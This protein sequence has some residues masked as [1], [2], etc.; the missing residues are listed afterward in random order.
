[1]DRV[2]MRKTRCR[3]ENDASSQALR[4]AAFFAFVV[5]VAFLASC[6]KVNLGSN[7]LNE[8]SGC[9]KSDTTR[10][11]F[12]SATP[13]QGQT[14]STLDFVDI[15]FTE[16]LKNPQPADVTLTSPADALSVSKIEKTSQYTYRLWINGA[17][18]NGEIIFSF[19]RLTD[20]NGNTVTGT[21]TLTG[22]VDIG[23]TFDQNLATNPG[24]RRG[25]SNQAGAYA[26]TTI[27]FKHDFDGDSVANGGTDANDWKV[28]RTTGVTAC[29]GAGVT[30]LASFGATTLAANSYVSFTLNEATD[31]PLTEQFYRIVVCVRNVAKNKFGAQGLLILRDNSA[32]TLTISPNTQIEEFRD[33]QSIA[34]TCSND[35][36]KIA[37]RVNSFNTWLGN[38]NDPA[39]PT[40]PDFTVTGEV[41]TVGGSVEYPT[42]LATPGPGFAGDPINPVRSRY[43]FR[44][45]DI[46][47]N[48][49]VINTA[50]SPIY[51]IDNT[52]PEVTVNLDNTFRAFI[53]PNIAMNSATTI[54]FTT[55]QPAGQAYKIK[56]G[57]TSCTAGG[58]DMATGLT[59]VTGN[60]ISHTFSTGTAFNEFDVGLHEV[61]VCV[62]NPTA[63]KWGVATLAV[64]NDNTIPTASANVASGTYGSLQSVEI[65]CTDNA[66]KLYLTAAET[67]GATPPTPPSDPTAVPE[68]QFSGPL[69]PRNDRTTIYKWLC[70][71]KAGQQSAIGTAQYTIDTVIPTVTIISNE[72]IAL[73]SVAGAYQSTNLTFKSSRGGLTYRIMRGTADCV[74][75][76]TQIGSD[77]TVPAAVSGVVPN[78][79]VPLGFA[80]FPT[81]GTNYD[82]KV[83]VFNHAGQP[84][85]NTTSLQIRRD[86]TAPAI[87]PANLPPSITAAGGNSYTVS[88][89]AAD[90]AAG[91]GVAVYRI[92]RD[93]AT[94]PTFPGY[95]NTPD[96]TSAA[97]AGLNS[98]TI[99]MP[100]A[101]KYY[102]RIVPVDAAGNIVALAASYNVIT[103]R[104]N[105]SVSVTGYSAGAGDF[106]V[107]QGTDTLAYNTA[108]GGAQTFASGFAPGSAY[109]VSVTAQ[110]TNQICSF[111]DKQFGT[112]TSDLTL[113]V[114]CLPGQWVGGNYQA[115]A[116]VPLNYLLYRGKVT[117]L[118]GS[119]VAGFADNT[120]GTSAQFQNPEFLVYLNSALYVADSNSR[121]V[122]R[123][124]LA[125]PYAVTTTAG[126]ASAAA[127]NATDDG[128]CLTAKFGVMTAIAT[129]GVNLYTA[130]HAP[131]KRIRK[132]SDIAG[133]CTVSTFA[134][135]GTS[136]FADGTATSAQFTD[137]YALSSDGTALYASDNGNNRIRKVDLGTGTVSTIA[138]NGSNTSTDA[139][140]GTSA[141]FH[142]MAGMTILGGDIYLADTCYTCTGNNGNKIRKISLTAPHA[143]STVAG[144]GGPGG[145][146]DGPAA[147]AKFN[148]PMALTT[149]GTFLFLADFNNSVIRR[150]DPTKSYWV[151]TLAGN[152]TASHADATG[153][154]AGI[155]NPHGIATDGRALYLAEWG[156]HRIKKLVDGG[157][158]GYWA[159]N[160]GVNPNDYSSDGAALANGSVV[161][162]PLSTTTDR[163]GNANKA[164]TFNGTTQYINAG[165]GGIPAN[166]DSSV[167][168][169]AWVK[170]DDL[171]QEHAI[172]GTASFKFRFNIATNGS[173]YFQNW[174]GG[175]AGTKYLVNTSGGLVTANKWVHIAYVR[176]SGATVLP[177]GRIYINGRDM[178]VSSTASGTA[179]DPV[180]VA[181][182]IGYST[183]SAIQRYMKGSLAD[184]RIYDRALDEGEIHELAQNA[185]ATEVGA[186]ISKGGTGLIMHYTLAN[187]TAPFGPAGSSL[188]LGGSVPALI[189][190]RDGTVNGAFYYD[191]LG[192]HFTTSKVGLPLGNAPRT[193]CG[194]VRPANKIATGQ[195]F[196]I[197][198]Y[199]LNGTNQKAGLWLR[200]NGG[201]KKLVNGG[202]GNDHEANFD[203]PINTWI[204]VCNTYDGTNSSLYANGR[205][206]GTAA[207][208][209]WNT[210]QGDLGIGRDLPTAGYLMGGLADIR[211]YN[212]ALSATQIRELA[213]QVPEGLVLRLDMNGDMND[214]SGLG[215]TVTSN[216][217]SLVAGRRGIAN[218]AY[219][220]TATQQAQIPH[221]EELMLSTNASWSF[222][223]KSANMSTVS[224]QIIG[225]YINSPMS[226]WVVKYD[227]SNFAHAWTGGTSGSQGAFSN[228]HPVPSSN[229]WNHFAY[230]RS[231]ASMTIYINGVSYSNVL[232]GD[233]TAIQPNTSDI[234]FGMGGSPGAITLQDLR[235]Y[236]RA[237]T[238]AEVQALAG[239]HMVQTASA[240]N[241][242]VQAD[243]FSNLSD[244]TAITGSWTN[245]VIQ[246]TL[247]PNGTAAGNPRYI[248]G[249]S[250]LLGGMPAVEFDGTAGKYFD[251]GFP[252]YNYAGLTVCT[253]ATRKSNGYR[254]LIEK[255][256]AVAASNSWGMLNDFP[257]NALKFEMDS[258]ASA[259]VVNAIADDTPAIYCTV[260]GTGNLLSSYING[261]PGPSTP[262]TM[263][264]GSNADR[265][266]VGARFDLAGSYYGQIGEVFVMTKDATA[267]ERRIAEC[268]LSA[269]YSIPLDGTP[270]PPVCP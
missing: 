52:L 203:F 247:G 120:T 161:A 34:V 134:G 142:V 74:T 236:N 107:Q 165:S 175:G 82:V 162:G 42:S 88:W 28:Y 72:H 140:V 168:L 53:T 178:T 160:P 268:Y 244:G 70:I 146:I 267:A 194:W 56:K 71:D 119:G 170:V 117:T 90:D 150:I 264:S 20:Y 147:T 201:V 113:N 13:A 125:A 219:H 167:T 63:T 15:T 98:A 76:A 91:S 198:Q 182:T 205:L 129:D 229:V 41:D 263:I 232:G 66:D 256:G 33:A 19:N 221:S 16:E 130:E 25:V 186:G 93:S 103:T 121:R 78:V 85:Y 215:H 77:Q 177:G 97:I 148:L 38:V 238:V 80:G 252:T 58:T 191:G 248:S 260:S 14:V 253:A 218:T 54:R 137:I 45:I 159:I 106:R 174:F 212:N 226:G 6:S 184:V 200:D 26:S 204:H 156:G 101:S 190:G 164:S 189:T 224:G 60:I 44:C 225:K 115:L 254:G 228:S 141:S 143:V 155:N 151:S 227:Q 231:G 65:T 127:G 152:G 222:W 210:Q 265:L 183:A 196:T 145:F 122:R 24:Y 23:I 18:Q 255:R 230:V 269:K 126:S 179:S 139:S 3:S 22:N 32:P 96:Y 193:H 50:T 262:K 123:V 62:S 116:P 242:H 48:K 243:T 206:L 261:H 246:A 59:P 239:Y 188:S 211:I 237:L 2:L 112:I 5:S 259:E 241:L 214:V 57:G 37:Y 68:Q 35:A 104:L 79:T 10:P 21:L 187:S 7:C 149:D 131:V 185:S 94:T 266:V 250:S 154:S 84:G 118:A 124:S 153:P 36:H 105:L 207:F 257:T 213:T 51:V 173:V 81:P 128:S 136:G 166:F 163:F 233:G 172:M 40:D 251:F 138:G 169:A 99:A 208:P 43:K 46:A 195:Y 217:G 180:N 135:S 75:G 114:K 61:R 55:N 17:V 83:C 133:T 8:K 31:F 258:T 109:N 110:P 47:G 245:S 144:V 240:L 64:T 100:D 270:T 69:T 202:G 132:I 92:Y 12:Y 157:L 192:Y 39:A 11:Q 209:A 111:T 102:L 89:N 95:P 30:Q 108:P 67:L 29:S 249:A 171:S 176:R 4:R 220:F 27:R 234:T 49:S 9:F 73:S 86:D 181:L 216:P 197:L 87:L 158:V 223:M 235:V 1:M 199:G